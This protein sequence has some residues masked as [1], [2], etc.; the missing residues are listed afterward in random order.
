MILEQKTGVQSKAAK[1]L[2]NELLQYVLKSNSRRNTIATASTELAASSSKLDADKA[3][4]DFDDMKN[5]E[6]HPGKLFDATSSTYTFTT[7]CLS[8]TT[9]STMVT[10]SFSAVQ[11]S[12]GHNTPISSVATSTTYSSVMQP[13]VTSI[14]VGVNAQLSPSDANQVR[15]PLRCFA[16][17]FSLLTCNVIFL[18]LLACTAN[19]CHAVAVACERRSTFS[20]IN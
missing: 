6:P 12:T 11:L 9:D 4:S 8:Q 5:Y 2:N 3:Q 7:T 16:T 17:R 19:D 14:E 20:A 15:V 13:A 1:D 18:L 10:P